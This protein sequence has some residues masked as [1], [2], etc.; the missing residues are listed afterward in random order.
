MQLI[1]PLMKRSTNKSK[2]LV[3]M[4]EFELNEFYNL[5]PAIKPE[6][7]AQGCILR[8]SMMYDGYPLGD[9]SPVKIWAIITLLVERT[10]HII[11]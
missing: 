11:F 1:F 4:N 8:Q 5:Y 9:D 10:W 6:G 2:I 7:Q 3:W